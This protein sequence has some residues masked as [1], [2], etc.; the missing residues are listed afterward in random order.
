VPEAVRESL[1]FVMVENMDQV[2]EHALDRG[3]P[4]AKPATT[5]PRPE[6]TDAGR[7][8]YAH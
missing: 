3:E 8:P 4:A 7:A 2:L 5:P 1:E 6:D